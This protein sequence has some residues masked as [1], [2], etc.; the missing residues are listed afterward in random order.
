MH[1]LHKLFECTFCQLEFEKGLASNDRLAVETQQRIRRGCAKHCVQ[2]PIVV[3]LAFRRS[4]S[5][6]IA[7]ALLDHAQGTIGQF[8][9]PELIGFVAPAVANNATIKRILAAE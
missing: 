3:C 2:L 7:A 4:S 9:L 5:V 1:L 6:E 8:H